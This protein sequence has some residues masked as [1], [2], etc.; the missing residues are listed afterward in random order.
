MADIDLEERCPSGIKG[1]DALVEG[2]FPRGRTIL[3]AGETGTGKTLFGIEFLCHGANDYNEP[4]ILL[5]LE[6]NPVEIK[7]DTRAFD[8][9]IEELESAGKIAIIDASLS[10]VGLEDFVHSEK[11]QSDFHISPGETNMSKL[12]E[13][14]T[15]TA[16][17]IGAKRVV[18]DSLPALDLM[19]EDQSK[20]RKM[21]L[22]MNYKLKDIGLTAI[23]ISEL[24]TYREALTMGIESY[25]ADGVIE[26][27]YRMSG[28][29]AGRSL[30]IKKMRGTN[31]SENIHPIQFVRGSGFEVRD[32]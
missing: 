13:I 1:F 26:L 31:H 25:L 29:A 9:N 28:E 17:K 14:I 12:F 20:V 10:K 3:V 21:L 30:T 16:K 23:L 22:Y 27:H 18:I 2:G 8:F 15:H 6:Q 11:S 5:A 24:S 19:F 32:L 4:G 7:K